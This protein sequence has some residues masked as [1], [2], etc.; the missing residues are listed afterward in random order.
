MIEA[1][2]AA[3]FYE[4]GAWDNFANHR[5][6]EGLDL[7]RLVTDPYN[8]AHL[9]EPNS[10]DETF[11]REY[12]SLML[13]SR[14]PHYVMHPVLSQTYAKYTNNSTNLPVNAIR[15]ILTMLV[16]RRSMF[17]LFV[18]PDERVTNTLPCVPTEAGSVKISKRTGSCDL[19]I[20]HEDWQRA[21]HTVTFVK[22]ARWVNRGL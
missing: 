9:G 12:K 16:V 13:E 3:D 11:R 5:S 2:L 4:C 18:L 15:P 19:E 1:D 20:H 10:R 8:R 7:E 6:H 17:M 14:G 22:R 21:Y